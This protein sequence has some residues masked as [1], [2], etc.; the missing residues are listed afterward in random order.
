MEFS[1]LLTRQS[2]VDGT[3]K[4]LSGN[5]ATPYE[6]FYNYLSDEQQNEFIGAQQFADVVKAR[7]FMV[8]GARLNAS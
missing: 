2:V 8:T 4:L 6:F 7:V 5:V 1:E 3:D